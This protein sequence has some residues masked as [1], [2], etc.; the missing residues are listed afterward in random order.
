MSIALKESRETRYWLRLLQESQLVKGNYQEYIRL[1]DEIIR[2]MASIVK[3][4][5]ETK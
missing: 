4:T 2:I 5:I 1:I 3:T